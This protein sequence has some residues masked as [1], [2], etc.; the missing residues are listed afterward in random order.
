MKY[1]L[2]QSVK[3][4]LKIIQAGIL[5]SVQD[6]GRFG[7]RH[8]GINT[9]G[10]MDQQAASIA[11]TLVGNDLNE[12]VIEMHFPAA[13]FLF[14][15]PALIA[16]AGA[17]FSTTINGKSVPICHPVLVDANTMLQFKKSIKGA[18]AYLA[19][20]GGIK[21]SPWLNSY[22]TNLQAGAGGFKGRRL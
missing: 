20:R 12:A 18:R 16:V 15:E 5:D 21:V 7:Y 1:V 2:F 9:G 6:S 8:L 3:M 22:S 10:C 17:D 14:E 11:N 4:N 19:I 13:D